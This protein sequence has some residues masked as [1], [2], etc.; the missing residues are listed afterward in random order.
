MKRKKFNQRE[1]DIQS[2]NLYTASIKQ[3]YEFYL[4]P[5]RNVQFTDIAMCKLSKESSTYCNKKQKLMK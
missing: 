5:G 1:E 2:Y 4:T 3:I